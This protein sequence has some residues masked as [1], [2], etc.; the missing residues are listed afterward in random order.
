MGKF[1]STILWGG[2]LTVL[3][4]AGRS[5][6]RQDSTGLDS[7]R[8][9][10]AHLVENLLL[11]Q[12]KQAQ[13]DSALRTQLEAEL[14]K[15]TGDQLKTRE[16]QSQ[17]KRLLNEDSIRKVQQLLRIRALKK[18]A[19]G[20]PVVLHDDTLFLLYT[21]TGS[22]S[23]AERANAV[24]QRI[25]KLYKDYRFL[26]DSLKLLPT[27]SGYDIVY[28]DDFTI[29]SVAQLDALWFDTSADSLAASYRASI[30]RE[31]VQEKKAN[32]LKNW[33]RRI[34]WTALVLLILALVIVGINRLFRFLKS[35]LRK[36]RERFAHGFTFRKYQLVT[37]RK[38]EQ[39]ALQ[40]SSVLKVML[41]LLAAYIALLLISGLFTA[42]EKWTGTLLGWI[43]TPARSM[44]HGFIHFLPNLFTIAVIYFIFRFIIRGIKYLSGEI[45]RGNLVITGFHEEWAQ[46]TFN[47]VKFLLY[48]FMVVLI[49]PYLPGS[50][51]TAFRG[52]SVF[53][54][55]L[56]SLGSSS[57][58]NNIVAGLVITY[59]RPFKVGDRVKI[60]DV[61][62]DILEKT[63]LVT[64]IRTIKNEDVTVPNS[65]ILSASSIN[66]SSNTKPEDT[67]LI[68]HTTVTIGYD[69]P[70]KEMHK[71]LI[72]AA[73][74]TDWVEKTPDP[75][76]LQTSLDDF[77]VSYQL[78]AYTREPNKQATIYSQ[79]HQNIQDACN[80]AGIEIM[81]P[82]YQAM[83]D[84]NATTIPPDY[85][86]K[87]Y[88]APP[89]TVRQKPG[90]KK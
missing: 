51:S 7:A 83:R 12:Q 66:F 18:N 31:I 20:Y 3:P 65:T 64:R 2:L 42:T 70:W 62:G 58:I 27:E 87:D 60:G 52:V 46:P 13:L 50:S 79:L 39:F 89:F 84:G 86:P 47:I 73:K 45:G 85:L 33:F 63:M 15:T 77:Y 28:R 35:F 81:S 36:N 30:I 72:E 61:T 37:P 1:Y 67:G 68:L 26:P 57:A 16:L 21:K 9:D 59:M 17:L 29:M 78:N 53:L 41:I 23:A 32:S 90:E 80:E 34:G 40:V 48:A 25:E 22:F 8:R 43:L 88:E 10:S 74:R 24:S 19:V 44:L 49:F 14:K 71:A 82:H 6:N 76:V 4:F 38:L 54:G 11:Q 55:V 69:V 56:I 75:F 5:Q